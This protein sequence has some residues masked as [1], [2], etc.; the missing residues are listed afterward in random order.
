MRGYRLLQWLGLA[1]RLLPSAGDHPA[2]RGCSLA[3]ARGEPPAGWTLLG[4]SAQARVARGEWQ[5]APVFLKV[6]LPR[7]RLEELKALGR[8]SRGARAVDR[9]I[10]MSRDGFPTPPVLAYGRVEARLEFVL[11]QAVPYP[12]MVELV[13]R[14]SGPARL[15]LADRRCLLRRFGAEIARLHRAGWV[16]GDL[17]LGN[18]LCD[19]QQG[20]EAAEFW[21]LDNEGS[22]RSTKPQDRHRNLIQLAMTRRDHQSRTDQVRMLKGYA[23][24]MGIDSGDFRQLARTVESA[25]ARRWARR[26]A[27]GGPKP[28]F[29]PEREAER[30]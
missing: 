11:T 15:N 24:G 30:R 13:T 10:Q 28:R 20:P 19:L 23:E 21:Y 7:H 8:G 2:L 18:V 16:H 5:G 3:V 6:L 22:H 14:T 25:R 12:A 17:R 9:S 29:H 27:R 1:P 4:S 26:M